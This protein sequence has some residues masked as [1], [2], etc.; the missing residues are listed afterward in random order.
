MSLHLSSFL[1]LLFFFFSFFNLF[2]PSTTFS[3]DAVW[4]QAALSLSA[5]PGLAL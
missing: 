5:L 1:N 2:A 4:M 3:L